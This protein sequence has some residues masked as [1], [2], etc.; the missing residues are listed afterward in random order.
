LRILVPFSSFPIE[1]SAILELVRQMMPIMQM[2]LL[3]N[4]SFHIVHH[5]GLTVQ[6]VN[7][8]TF[9]LSKD[10]WVYIPSCF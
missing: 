9:G 3:M 4:P 10:F 7:W 6:L 8:P 5:M 2:L 1:D